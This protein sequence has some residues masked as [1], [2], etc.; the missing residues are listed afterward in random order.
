MV[1]MAEPTLSLGAPGGQSDSL[2]SK[3]STQGQP[4]KPL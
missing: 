1:E 4:P 3:V 2:A